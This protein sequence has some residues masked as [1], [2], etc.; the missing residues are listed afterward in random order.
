MVVTP[1]GQFH[2]VRTNPNLAAWKLIC[3]TIDNTTND[4][5]HTY[6]IT[7]SLR[8][9]NLRICLEIRYYWPSH[10]TNDVDTTRSP[11][12]F[13]ERGVR[14]ATSRQGPTF[15]EGFVPQSTDIAVSVYVC[16]LKINTGKE[17]KWTKTCLDLSP[18]DQRF[19]A[20]LARSILIAR[21]SVGIHP[22]RDDLD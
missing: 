12:I 1:G 10:H 8:T 3:E 15:E 13:Y 11:S 19:L 6:I 21:T 14:N 2:N 22:T 20:E 17:R 7:A 4:M 18:P 16:T 9:W 5:P